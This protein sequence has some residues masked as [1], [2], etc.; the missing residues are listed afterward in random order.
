MDVAAQIEAPA[1]GAAAAMQAMDVDATHC[2]RKEENLE[3]LIKCAS[4]NGFHLKYM[5]AYMEGGRLRL[6]EANLIFCVWHSLVNPFLSSEVKHRHGKEWRAAVPENPEKQTSEGFRYRDSHHRRDALLRECMCAVSSEDDDG[7]EKKAML[8]EHIPKRLYHHH[9][10]GLT[11]MRRTQTLLEAMRDAS[12][13]YKT[14]PTVKLYRP[15]FCLFS[16]ETI[17]K[18]VDLQQVAKLRDELPLHWGWLKTPPYIGF[19]WRVR[20]VETDLPVDDASNTV[21]PTICYF[22]KA[23]VEDMNGDPP[24]KDTI[25]QMGSIP[26]DV[27]EVSLRRDQTQLERDYWGENNLREAERHALNRSLLFCVGTPAKGNGI[28]IRSSVAETDCEGVFTINLVAYIARG[29]DAGDSRIP[30]LIYF[31]RLGRAYNIP[32]C[33]AGTVSL[34]QE[35]TPATMRNQF[36]PGGC[37]EESRVAH[38]PRSYMAVQGYELDL[39]A[40]RLRTPRPDIKG[41]KACQF[42]PQIDPNHFRTKVDSVTVNRCLLVPSVSFWSMK[43]GGQSKATWLGLSFPHAVATIDD[44]NRC[45]VTVSRPVVL[46][47][48]VYLPPD[49]NTVVC[50]KSIITALNVRTKTGLP[51]M[52]E[53]IKELV[54]NVGLYDEDGNDLSKFIQPQTARVRAMKDAIV[55][56]VFE[57]SPDILPLL[58]ADSVHR[59]FH[60]RVESEM[61]EMMLS[62]D[63][64]FPFCIF[65]RQIVN[66]GHVLHEGVAFNEWG[67]QVDLQRQRGK[68]K[69]I[70]GVK[71]ETTM[72]YDRHLERCG[73][74]AAVDETQYPNLINQNE[75]LTREVRRA[76]PPLYLSL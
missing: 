22:I 12:V 10:D 64:H 20:M 16:D 48:F 46:G 50:D 35:L 49:R 51:E 32:T 7:Q 2:V 45:I 31:K 30:L 44:T 54:F 33:S 52:C 56:F 63:A 68:F 43:P 13:D 8:M 47:F 59:K 74:V 62:K 55:H 61:Q 60:F 76:P 28:R 42:V 27:V 70:P 65:P 14:S 41:A 18:F 39:S 29:Y 26:E 37:F 36:A 69:L 6:S 21:Q 34:M 5:E 67:R 9:I 23:R 1:D 53:E 71:L 72:S 40:L 11:R 17:D 24:N 38:T 3:T 25:A 4:S 19:G 57:I 75:A 66:N 73:R 15:L 58:A